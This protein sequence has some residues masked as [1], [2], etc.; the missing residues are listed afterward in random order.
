MENLK[1][2]PAAKEGDVLGPHGGFR[3]VWRGKRRRF[4]RSPRPR[5]KNT[6]LQLA[7]CAIRARAGEILDA[8]A[9]DMAQ[10][11]GNGVAGAFLDRPL[12]R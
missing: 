7:A 3:G 2:V 5:R 11:K 1:L 6:A 8:N 10:A 4:W 9:Q 12:S